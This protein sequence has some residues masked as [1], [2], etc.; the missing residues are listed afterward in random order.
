MTD[1]IKLK[2]PYCPGESLHQQGEIISGDLSQASPPIFAGQLRALPETR[3][4]T[5]REHA[6]PLRQDLNRGIRGTRGSEAGKKSFRV[7]R[8]FRGSAFLPFAFF[9]R[10]IF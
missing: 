5:H 3:N 1:R 10:V 7:F 9:V 4:R 6:R 8:V 2:R